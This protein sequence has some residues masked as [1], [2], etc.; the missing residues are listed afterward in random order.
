[1]IPSIDDIKNQFNLSKTIGEKIAD[2]LNIKPDVTAVLQRAVNSSQPV[3]RVVIDS[4]HPYRSILFSIIKDADSLKG[5]KYSSA[6]NYFK[7]F[8]WTPPVDLRSFNHQIASN[9]IILFNDLAVEIYLDQTVYECKNVGGKVAL[10]EFTIQDFKNNISDITKYWSKERAR[11]SG[12]DTSL[13]KVIEFREPGI[14][15]FLT[16]P[17]YENRVEIYPKGKDGGID[18]AYTLMIQIDDF[19]KWIPDPLNISFKEFREVLKAADIKMDSDDPSYQFQ[20]F[21]KQLQSIDSA[22]Y[23]TNAPD[24]GIWKKR[25]DGALLTKHL[26]WLLHYINFHI[27]AMYRKMKD[28]HLEKYGKVEPKVYAPGKV[29]VKTRSSKDRVPRT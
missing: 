13:T 22:I 1:M 2:H 27:P 3:Y 26:Y 11:V 5:G 12:Q 8:R 9:S 15:V 18:N 25:H 14:F 10:R 4:R 24:K 21:R 28:Y 19:Y 16:E 29:K 20:G 23:P 6:N 7:N 17:T